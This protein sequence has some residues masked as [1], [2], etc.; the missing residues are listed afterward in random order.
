MKFMRFMMSPYIL[1]SDTVAAIT[2]GRASTSSERISSTNDTVI[3]AEPA[4]MVTIRKRIL[5]Y[6]ILRLVITR[7]A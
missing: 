2:T 7:N 3:A 4:A 6:G 5:S 1:N